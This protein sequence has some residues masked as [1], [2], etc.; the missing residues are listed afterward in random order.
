[1]PAT[2]RSMAAIRCAL[3][4]APSAASEAWTGSDSACGTLSSRGVRGVRGRCECG[5]HT[6]L[7]EGEVDTLRNRR[8]RTC[9]KEQLRTKKSSNG[10]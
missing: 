5:I 4:F 7:E 10:S 9:F 1:V 6:Q 3:P 2:T 8:F